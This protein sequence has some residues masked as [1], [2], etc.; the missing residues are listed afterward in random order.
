MQSAPIIDT[1]GQNLLLVRERADVDSVNAA[2]YGKYPFPW[3]THRLERPLDPDFERLMLCQDLGDWS[4]R[5]IPERPSI[6]VAGCGTNQAVMTALAFARATVVGS[7]V[8]AQS[9]EIASRSA[10]D[11]GLAN[12][13]LRV[14]SLNAVDYR[15]QFD[16]VI[17]TG[18]IHH[19]ASPSDALERLARALKPGGVLQLMVYNR[20]QRILSSCVQKA[21]RLLTSALNPGSDRERSLASALVRS[22]E[23]PGRMSEF[24]RG[25][26]NARVEELADTLM[27]PVEHSYTV[28]SL[29]E[30][31]QQAGLRIELPCLNQ[32]DRSRGNLDWNLQLADPDLDS[33]Y[34]G[35][36]D[37]DRWYVTNL[38]LCERSPLLWFY[39]RR[40]NGQ[41]R[42]SEEQVCREFLDRRFARTA[43]RRRGYTLGEDDRYRPSPGSIEYPPPAENP[44]RA[45]IADTDSSTPMRTILE[46]HGLPTQFP[47]VNLCRLRLATTAFPYLRAIDD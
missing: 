44:Y 11:L 25:M 16:Y 7:D 43:S 36:P 9:V 23:H 33:S 10:S 29:N 6:W 2:F 4:H 15:D 39:L 22:F 32:F 19:N 24:L 18:V 35:L 37:L 8:S 27:Q 5:L 14:E 45:V 17:C 26:R 34:R 28:A 1:D 42:V 21:L 40:A 31:A 12:L 20:Y 30:M 13:T 47:A 3:R 46:R 41:P 38:L